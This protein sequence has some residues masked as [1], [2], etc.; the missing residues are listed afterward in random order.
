MAIEKLNRIA[1]SKAAQFV[2]KGADSV[3]S[4]IGS[5]VN[6]MPKKDT[7]EK[8]LKHI[9][10][11]GANNSFVSLATLMIGGVVIPRI[12]TAAKRNPD[13]KEA[14]KDELK[15]IL[16]R[17]VQ[18]VII[19]LFALKAVTSLIT[20]NVSKITGLPLTSKPYQRVFNNNSEK[21]LK[22][23]AQ[24]A[25]EFMESP[26]EKLK[27]I[28]K[29]ILDTIHPTSGVVALKNNE[30]ISKYSGYNSID[31][32]LKVF[33]EIKNQNGSPDK[34]FKKVIDNLIEKQS[35]R[36]ASLKADKLAGLSVDM[37]PAQKVLTSL[38]EVEKTGIDALKDKNLDEKV[39]EQLIDFFSRK[40]N[41]LVSDVKA[42]NGLIRTGA[43][44]F[45]TMYLGFGLPKL[46]QRRLEKKYL[47]QK[48]DF[49]SAGRRNEIASKSLLNKNIKPQEVRLYGD[50]VK[51]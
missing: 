25:Q 16:F 3:C 13:D 18:T 44:A 1:S 50:F 45:E 41:R 21:G 38:Q 26:K 4:H 2:R 32:I 19:M 17:D 29:N 46:N 12:I 24:K 31:E 7:F 15:E 20:G 9:E 37:G 27:M 14:T 22:G 30:A 47:N 39:K 33:D 10:P 5:V 28:G 11:T 36:V 42:L 40:D 8:F 23:I 51:K 49:Y 35:A 6:K 34:V 48:E 43:L